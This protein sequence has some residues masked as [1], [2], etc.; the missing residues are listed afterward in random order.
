MIPL[1]FA[2]I[3]CAVPCY[4]QQLLTISTLS[5]QAGAAGSLDGVTTGARFNKPSGVA[6]D[7]FGNVYVADAGNQTIREILAGGRVITL[8]G[9]VG[10]TGTNDGT[11]SAARFTYPSAVAVDGAGNLYVADSQ[12]STIRKVAPGGIV[13]T[14][15]GMP[16]N[17]GSA[18]GAG[19]NARFF[20]PN[21]VAVDTGGNVY[22][23]DTGNSTIRKITLAGVVTTLAGSAGNIGSADGPGNSARFYMPYGVVVDLA[24]NVYVTDTF[25]N[26]VRKVTAGGVVSTLAGLAGASGSAD[27]TGSNARFN[28]P[29]GAAAVDTAGNLYLADYNN[30][31]IRKITPAGAVTT[32]AGLAGSSGANDG[33]G[34]VARFY[35]PSGL[36]VDSAGDVFIADT[37]NDTIREGLLPIIPPPITTFAGLAGSS[38][39]TDG[40]GSNA[41]FN[42]PTSVALDI[43]GNVYVA[44]YYNATVRMIN[45]SGTVTTLAGQAGTVG[46]ANGSGSAARFYNPSGVTVDNSYNVYVADQGNYTIRKITGGVVSTLAGLAGSAGSADG[47]GSAARFY[48]PAAVAVDGAGNVYVA[49]GGNSTIRKITSAG[50]VTTLAGAAGQMGNADGTGSSARFSSPSGIAL[51]Y[52]TNIGSSAEFVGEIAVHL[53]SSGRLTLVTWAVVGHPAGRF[54]RNRAAWRPGEGLQAIPARPGYGS[55]RGRQGLPR[56]GIQKFRLSF[57]EA[58]ESRN[59]WTLRNGDPTLTAPPSAMRRR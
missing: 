41:R 40:T 54:A 22:V 32:L 19:S 45:P 37:E 59:F 38:G 20:E 6:A 34:S 49:D 5:G 52:Q 43:A 55:G 12:N 17:S 29:D 4:G 36:A 13:T 28:G 14:F 44:D 11:G 39:S 24:G 8:A 3:L 58:L 1:A 31:T 16:G 23:A 30:N 27:G 33:F 10:I 7:A 25:N 26:T 15:A 53:S 56:N 18:D 57:P 47:T 50:I 9:S 35:N 2:A 51:D 46:S 42:Q 48:Y 21:G